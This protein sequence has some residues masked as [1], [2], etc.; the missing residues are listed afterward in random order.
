[1]QALRGLM[2]YIR[3]LREFLRACFVEEVEYRLNFVGHLFMTLF[4]I[5]FAVITVNI[6]FFRATSIGGWT[7][8]EML[9]LLGVFNIINGFIEMLLQPNM[10]RLVQHIRKGTLDYVLLKPVDSQFFVSFRHMVFWKMTDI[11]LGFGL[12]AYAL[13]RIGTVPS[14][15][16]IFVFLILLGAGLCLVY[17]LWMMLMTFSFWAVK[18]DNLS[19]L[20]MMFFDTARVP[21]SVY[22]GFLRLVLLYIFPI[23]LMTSVPASALTGTL[24]GAQVIGSL[25]LAGLFLGLTRLLWKMALRSYTSAS[26]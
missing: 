16:Q 18:V 9:L 12:V 25:L 22:K 11:L 19:Y 10:T 8:D 14:G 5:V 23:G 24:S 17:S 6:F 2:K 20:F 13:M 15:E 26:S 21:V 7:F 3:L 4:G 1:M